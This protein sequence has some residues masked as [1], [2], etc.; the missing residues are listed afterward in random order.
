MR[1][2]LT[3]HRQA[4][5]FVLSRFLKNKLSTLFICLS[6][7]VTLALP[8]VAYIILHNLN[9]LV[10]SV[11][12]ESK[13]S[14]FLNANPTK[15]LT[16]DIQHA[17]EQNPAV[18]SVIFVSKQDALEQL[19]AVDSNKFILESLQTNP[20]PDAFFVEPKQ[21]D[22]VSI[23]SLKVELSN[24]KGVESVL[25]ED[26]W[27]KRLNYLLLLGKNILIILSTLLGFALVAVIGNTIRM[28]ILTQRAEIELSELIGATK[29]FIRRPFLYVGALYG[30]GGGILAIIITFSTVQF[31]NQTILKITS[32]YQINF[33]LGFLSNFDI[34]IILVSAATLG[35]LSS[36]LS[37][38]LSN[39]NAL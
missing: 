1:T 23:D 5:L 19:T 13:L 25:V 28:Q 9:G 33:S 6:I 26:A 34:L 22:T 27:I 12:S 24:I 3:H 4:L 37:L 16:A 17:I 36:Y 8:S 30:L 29:S 39:K 31:L 11:K 35:W 2:W 15:E 18:Q 10:G 21:L 20:L 14:V 7:G 32:A 38:L